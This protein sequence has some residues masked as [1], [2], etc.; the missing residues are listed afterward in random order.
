M[1]VFTDDQVDVK[2]AAEAYQILIDGLGDYVK[3]YGQDSKYLVDLSS[4][5]R[6]YHDVAFGFVQTNNLTPADGSYKLSDEQVKAITAISKG[7]GALKTEATKY[8]GEC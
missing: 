5:A 1:K 4:L 3:K 8:L 2:R 6:I 7:D